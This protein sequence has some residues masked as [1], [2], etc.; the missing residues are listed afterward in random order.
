MFDAQFLI[1]FQRFQPI[2]DTVFPVAK[3]DSNGS[4]ADGFYSDLGEAANALKFDGQLQVVCVGPLLGRISGHGSPKEVVIPNDCC[5][6]GTTEN[7]A[8]G[9]LQCCGRLRPGF[10]L[11]VILLNEIFRSLFLVFLCR[12][13]YNAVDS[14]FF[15]FRS[16][17]VLLSDSQNRGLEISSMFQQ[18]I[19]AEFV[20]RSLGFKWRRVRGK[21]IQQVGTFVVGG[22]R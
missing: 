9:I 19:S 20:V 13:P 16:H 2:N 17:S 11:F 3:C 12:F 22:R 18:R 8:Y 14:G 21:H 4:I 7:G 10:F 15:I 5:E 1:P 6:F